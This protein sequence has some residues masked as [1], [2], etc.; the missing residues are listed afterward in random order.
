MH[1]QVGKKLKQHV[2]YKNYVDFTY[3]Y[4]IERKRELQRVYYLIMLST[5]AILKAQKFFMDVTFDVV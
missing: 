3:E 2:S 4:S 5:F 1:I